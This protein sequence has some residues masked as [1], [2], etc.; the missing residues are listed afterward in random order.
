[1]KLGSETRTRL[2]K[3]IRLLGSDN[4]GEVAAAAHKLQEVLR[5]SGADLHDLA[6]L[7]EDERIDEHGRRAGHAGGSQGPPR[8]PPRS[9][10]PPPWQS[11][12]PLPD[13]AGKLKVAAVCI[14]VI[15]VLV[16]AAVTTRGLVTA[17]QPVSTT[18][19]TIPSPT[20]HEVAV[21]PPAPMLPPAQ[22]PP[23]TQ[24]KQD[25][26]PPKLLPALP[27]PKPV[28]AKP[29]PAVDTPDARSAARSA[30]GEM[31]RQIRFPQPVD[32]VTTM[33]SISAYGSEIVAS[34]RA[35]V[36]ANAMNEDAL[37]RRAL[38]T[39]CHVPIMVSALN[40]G[41]T[42]R[43]RYTDPNG[44]VAEVVIAAKDCHP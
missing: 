37:R 19:T 34:Y 38:E 43:A 23:T 31:I 41:A 30:V 16:G 39:A 36:A 21:A 25:P 17:P 14:V 29:E 42:H 9:A 13:S 32:R 8:P 3:L 15:G 40:R 12:R 10:S 35:A 4:A 27:R 20:V 18:A 28:L 24:P 7:L 6:A 33:V 22:Q 1:M 2:A 11:E 5:S 44:A 26:L